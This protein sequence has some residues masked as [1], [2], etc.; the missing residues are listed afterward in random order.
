M[1]ILDKSVNDIV[2][3]RDIRRNQTFENGFFLVSLIFVQIL[4]MDVGLRA[5]F[6]VGEGAGKG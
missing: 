2:R 5:G 3:D 4:E 1:R 6:H